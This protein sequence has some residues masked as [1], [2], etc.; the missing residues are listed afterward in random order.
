MLLDKRL[1]DSSPEFYNFPLGEK[2]F[3]WARR[4][5][6]I[7]LTLPIITLASITCL[8][9]NFHLNFFFLYNRTSKK[10]RLRHQAW[11]WPATPCLTS[12]QTSDQ[13]DL[14]LHQHSW[15]FSLFFEKILNQMNISFLTLFKMMMVSQQ[16]PTCSNKCIL[17]MQV[18]YYRINLRYNVPLSFSKP[19]YQ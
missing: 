17:I 16:A 11:Q 2:E 19:E 4:G 1:S 15:S 7:T 18:T 8:K 12:I 6:L 14:F 3:K 13:T 9:G 10:T 5:V